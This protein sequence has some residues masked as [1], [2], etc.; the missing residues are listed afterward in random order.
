[1][2]VGYYRKWLLNFAKNNEISVN[3]HLSA[4]LKF[5]DELEVKYQDVVMKMFVQILKGDARTW[6][7][8]LPNASIDGWKY[9]KGNLHKNG[10]TNMIMNSY[11]TCFIQLEKVKMNIFLNSI[12]V[13]LSF[14]L[15]FIVIYILMKNMLCFITLKHSM[16]PLVFFLGKRM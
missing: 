13:L 1:M 11:W 3:D 10:I 5:V 7:K 14:I 12:I 16:N 4:L 6:Y 15:K 2:P 9:F 8:S